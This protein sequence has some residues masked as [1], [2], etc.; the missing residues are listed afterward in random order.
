MLQT[1]STKIDLIRGTGM[2]IKMKVRNTAD[3]NEALKKRG[4]DLP[5]F[6]VPTQLEN[7]APVVKLLIKDNLN[8]FGV[9]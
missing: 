9:W 3:Y 7:S 6:F 2:P 8:S 1:F 5:G 4:S